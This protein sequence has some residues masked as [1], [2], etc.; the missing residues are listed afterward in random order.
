MNMIT[1]WLTRKRNRAEVCRYLLSRS[2]TDYGLPPFRPRLGPL[3]LCSHSLSDSV[4]ADAERS[5]MLGL[6][7]VV[8]LP[9]P[10]IAAARLARYDCTHPNNII[11]IQTSR[12][13]AGAPSSRLACPRNIID[14]TTPSRPIPVPPVPARVWR[15][16]IRIRP[17][18]PRS[19]SRR[20][21][22]D[23]VACG[24]W[25]AMWRTDLNRCK[26]HR[27][28]RVRRVRL[29]NHIH[30]PCFSG[31]R[32]GF[33]ASQV[34]REGDRLGANKGRSLG[35]SFIVPYRSSSRIVHR[36]VSFIVPGS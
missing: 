14:V 19:R 13:G 4:L 17:N 32:L 26:G 28:S 3:S 16:R 33:D 1:S 24:M 25:L 20:H 18:P 12:C 2:D 30:A 7:G 5:A 31:R 15:I 34:R 23:G 9:S 36:P 27:A 11:R 22:Q 8:A 21:A 35:V 6:L 10:Q 29:L